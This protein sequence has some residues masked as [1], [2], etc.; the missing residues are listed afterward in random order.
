M[1]DEQRSAPTN[2]IFLCGACHD[3]VDNNGGPAYPEAVL[4]RWREEHTAKVRQLLSSPHLPLLPELMRL[5]HNAKVVAQVFDILANKR[6][7]H[8]SVDLETWSHVI[9]SLQDLRLEITRA[10]SEISED[11]RL[12]KALSAIRNAA[13]RF[14]KDVTVEEDGQPRRGQVHAN[15]HLETM[16]EEI[17]LIV[18][19]LSRTYNIPIPHELQASTW[20][21]G[22]GL[23]RP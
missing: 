17:G 14:M 12:R 11:N 23:G 2:A 19:R 4:T 9:T 3:L 8:F 13:M 18:H 20:T 10:L 15:V 16:R 5:Q 6:S 7:L 22:V 21:L 1:T